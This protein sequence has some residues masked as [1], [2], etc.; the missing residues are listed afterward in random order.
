MNCLALL[1][2]LFAFMVLVL[3]FRTAPAG[4]GLSMRGSGAPLIPA[5]PVATTTPRQS[6]LS[7]DEQNRQVQ[8]AVQSSRLAM[9]FHI[10]LLEI[11]KQRLAAIPD[12]TCTFIRQERIDGEELG[13]IQTCDLKLRHQPFSVYMK[14]LEGGD[15]GREL[16]FVDGLND[17]RM[18][19]KLGGGKKMLPALKLDPKGSLALRESRHPINELGMLELCELI[20]AYR[21][22]DVDVKECRW[23][24]LNDQRVLDRDCYGFIVEYTDPSFEPVYR[25]SVTYIDK[26]LSLPICVRNY[27]WPAEGVT[28]DD[29]QTLDEATLIEYYAYRDIKFDSRLTDV[30][31]DRANTSYRFKR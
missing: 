5:L 16:L 31:F 21:K 17:N 26:Q 24:M 23:Q 20:L 4:A 3:G 25:K 13:E 19:V 11:A 1:V 2:C 6:A 9:E 18:I 10:A 7:A 12:Y 30:D 22:R 14:W 28:Y 15:V 8:A 27:S 29:P